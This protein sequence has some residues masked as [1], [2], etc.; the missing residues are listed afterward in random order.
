MIL[1]WIS[2]GTPGTE[3]RPGQTVRRRVGV[4]APAS[5]RVRHRANVSDSG[6]L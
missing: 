5:V 3:S 6:W 1:N 2:V 4:M